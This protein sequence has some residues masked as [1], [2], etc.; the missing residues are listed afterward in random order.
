[1]G[2]CPCLGPRDPA[3]KMI[4]AKEDTLKLSS[5]S[6]NSIKNVLILFTYLN[7]LKGLFRTE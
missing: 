5:F 4:M 6:I 3:E 1:M 7:Q 2:I